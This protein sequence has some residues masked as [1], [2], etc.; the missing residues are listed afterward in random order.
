VLLLNECLLL[1]ISLRLSPETFG[2]NLVCK[3]KLSRYL[4]MYHAMKTYKE[5]DIYLHATSALLPGTHWI[6][7]SVGPTSG[8]D[9][10]GK[11]EKSS[12]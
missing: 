2:Y 11:R 3:V 6:G 5:V 9:V 7:Q 10:A 8:M 4:T 1:F 12:P